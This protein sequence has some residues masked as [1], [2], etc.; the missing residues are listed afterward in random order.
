M[1]PTPEGILGSKKGNTETE[2]GE[3]V[4]KT[5]YFTKLS[6]FN[7]QADWQRTGKEQPTVRNYSEYA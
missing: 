3:T 2:K 4:M 1:V 5:W 6:D 7:E